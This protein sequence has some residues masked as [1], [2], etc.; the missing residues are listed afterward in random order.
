MTAEIAD[1]DVE[2]G[3]NEVQH[4]AFKNELVSEPMRA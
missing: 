4:K 2:V 3:P 1:S